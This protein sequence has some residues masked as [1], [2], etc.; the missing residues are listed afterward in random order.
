MANLMAAAGSRKAP[1]PARRRGALA[2]K[3]PPFQPVQLAK[4]V[5]K[6]PTGERWLHEMK[7]D[8]YRLEVAVGGGDTADG[9]LTCIQMGTIE[10]HG[11]ARG[12]RTSR[13][14]TGW[15][16]ILIPMKG[17]TSRLCGGL[18]STSAT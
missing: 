2:L 6:I 4:L 8:G 9:L 11:G 14:R 17:S 16:S 1:K 7:Y 18:L 15:Y 10:F 12:S 5:D 3:P 13:R